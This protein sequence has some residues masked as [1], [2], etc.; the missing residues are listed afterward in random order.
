MSYLKEL[1][2]T[3]EQ[4]NG[5]L[6]IAEE[7]LSLRIAVGIPEPKYLDVRL[8]KGSLWLTHRAIFAPVTIRQESSDTYSSPQ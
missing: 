2:L 8:P 7:A 3:P 1:A 5:M 4:A 6:D